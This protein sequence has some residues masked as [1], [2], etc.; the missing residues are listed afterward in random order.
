MTLIQHKN[1]DLNDKDQEKVLSAFLAG[2]NVLVE[3][4]PGTGKTF[5]G[6]ILAA[7][8]LRHRLLPDDSKVLFL[9]FSKNARIQIEHQQSRLISQ[10]IISQEEKRRIEISN[11]HSFFLQC[12][13][14]RKALWG[15]K[16]KLR[17]GSIKERVGKL[18]KLLK[19]MP[20]GSN[21][22]DHELLTS[23]FSLK[24][25]NAEELF[26]SYADKCPSCLVDRAFNIACGYLSN[27]HLH[28]DD[29]APLMLDLLTSNPAFLRYIKTTY[30]VLVLDEFQDTDRLQW[31]IIKLWQPARLVILYDRFQMIY[32]WRGSTLKRIQDA[33]SALGPFEEFELRTIHRAAGGGRGL[34]TFLMALRED[35]L[36]GSQA[37]MLPALSLSEWLKV[38]QMKA[39]STIPPARRALW[40]T[41]SIL[42][43]CKDT[44]KSAA[45][46]TRGTKLSTELH[47]L[48]SHRGVSAN[49]P[50]FYCR[51]I[52]SKDGIEDVLRERIEELKDVR[53]V[54]DM[55]GWAGEAIN[56]LMGGKGRIVVSRGKNKTAI[57]FSKLIK[58]AIKSN[59]SETFNSLPIGRSDLPWWQKM[60]PSFD[61][62]VMEIRNHGIGNIGVCLQSIFDIAREAAEHYKLRLD[63]DVLYL[64]KHLAKASVTLPIDADRMETIERL[65]DRLMQA[66]HLASRRT[67]RYPVFLVAH[68][69]KGR[70]FDHVIIPWLANV[71]EDKTSYS[72]G[73]NQFGKIIGDIAHDEEERR[74]LYVAISRAK[75]QI[76]ILYPEE[77]PSPILR[78]WG[79]IRNKEEINAV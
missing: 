21:G 67:S 26:G 74:I 76:T 13:K 14:K 54:T 48:L 45:I 7:S 65:E 11:Y 4:P 46:I 63:P 19:E 43:N 55:A 73:M 42:N 6:V 1:V 20:E 71:P 69:S 62:L 47:Q 34:A 75:E 58:Q 3:A 18:K 64:F 9:T 68:Q 23:A 28:Y 60:Q 24:R 79:L 56:I 33:K 72:E 16:G 36:R 41:I 38:E 50:S 51:R 27:G 61:H 8:C 37:S 31:E 39:G 52:A 22:A 57:E 25:F 35:N 70:E 12:L 15:V 49:R 59:W 77:S 40:P 66:T 53:T 10:Q 78:E 2:A 29:F 17:V 32:E 44:Q 30:P 5:L